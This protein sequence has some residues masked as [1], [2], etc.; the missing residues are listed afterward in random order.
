MRNVSVN[1]RIRRTRKQL[2]M[3]QRE[4]ANHLQVSQGTVSNYENGSSHHQPEPETWKQMAE[5]LGV[6]VAF[7]KGTS[8]VDSAK[9]LTEAT[10]Q[11]DRVTSDV[12]DDSIWEVFHGEDL[13][14]LVNRAHSEL[15]LG[16]Y[17]VENVNVQFIN[18][19]Y[20]VTVIAFRH[21]NYE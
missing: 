10:S 7:L 1:N 12:I 6:T 3:S 21:S 18:N 11:D 16:G 13:H 9:P 8:D 19:E 4:L 15:P 17:I 14:K 2:G 20:V 5:I